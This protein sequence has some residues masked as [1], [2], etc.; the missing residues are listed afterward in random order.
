MAEEA[1][2]GDWQLCVTRVPRCRCGGMLSQFGLRG[3]LKRHRARCR[4]VAFGWHSCEHARTVPGPMPWDGV[5]RVCACRV[6]SDGPCGAVGRGHS[7][8][9]ARPC[10]GCTAVW[11]PPGWVRPRWCGVV[12]RGTSIA[13]HEAPVAAVTRVG[14]AWLT[15]LDLDQVEPGVPSNRAPVTGS[16]RVFS[17]SAGSYITAGEATDSDLCLVHS[18]HGACPC[19][20]LTWHDVPGHAGLRRGYLLQIRWGRQWY[21]E[22]RV[23]QRWETLHR[24]LGLP[25]RD[26]CVGEGGCVC[27][28]CR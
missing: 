4:C 6:L 13:S 11:H 23:Q 15:L 7:R 3:K 5:C 22:S 24:S 28:P 2:H 17:T 1:R 10:A 20:A 27:S 8:V 25:G 21:R 9:G 14:K 12:E 26:W 19:S 18:R 16:Q